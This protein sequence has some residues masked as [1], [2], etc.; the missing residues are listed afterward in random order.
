MPSRLIEIPSNDIFKY[1]KLGLE[2]AIA[3]RTRDILS[4][5]PQAIAIDGHWGTGDGA[6]R[7]RQCPTS[8]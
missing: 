1:D 6:A 3:S 5:S 4:R 2:P 8:S 7:V